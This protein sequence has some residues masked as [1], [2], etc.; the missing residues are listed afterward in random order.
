MRSSASGSAGAAP[1]PAAWA[2]SERA[3][4]SDAAREPDASLAERARS[5][6]RAAFRQ[7]YERYAAMVNALALVYA[8]PADAEDLVQ[9]VFFAAWR[10]LDRLRE[11][12]KLGPWLAGIA[13]VLARRRRERAPLAT[14]ELGE[15]LVARED[16][17]LAALE[18]A[19]QSHAI[20]AQLRALPEAYRETLALRLVEGLDGPSIARLTGL[21]HGSVRVN[22]TRGMKL[23]RERLLREGLA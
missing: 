3:P 20:L 18:S 19:E 8:P 10:G 14:T 2:E 15:E 9:Q 7:L 4:A 11:L 13:R 12:D 21:S 6:D 1:E 16:A 23:L 5:G 17:Q 22:L